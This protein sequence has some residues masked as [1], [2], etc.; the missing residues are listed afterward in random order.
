[1]VFITST[2]S[3]KYRHCSCAI[4]EHQRLHLLNVKRFGVS[5]IRYIT[6]CRNI[7][8]TKFLQERISVSFISKQPKNSYSCVINLEEG[9]KI[10]FRSVVN[11]ITNN[12]ETSVFCNMGFNELQ[13]CRGDSSTSLLLLSGTLQTAVRCGIL[14]TCRK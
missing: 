14:K 6:L 11:N 1:V 4:S 7:K 10:T 13:C 5:V 2:L 8:V 12:T 3:Q 9:S